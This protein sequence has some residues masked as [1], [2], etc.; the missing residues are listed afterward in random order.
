MLSDWLSRDAIFPYISYF[1]NSVTKVLSQSLLIHLKVMGQFPTETLYFI[2]KWNHLLYWK[3]RDHFNFFQNE[4][5]ADF[6]SRKVQF[7]LLLMGSSKTNV[8]SNHLASHLEEKK[9]NN[10]KPQHWKAVAN[11]SLFLWNSCLE[12]D[13]VSN[14]WNSISFPTLV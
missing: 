4:L 3:I 13:I 9:K 6:K 10:T 2:T 12:K 11:F 14:F 1:L 7:V 8:I 5:P